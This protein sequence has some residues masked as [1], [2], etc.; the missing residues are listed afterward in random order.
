MSMY[1]IKDFDVKPD[2]EIDL[3]STDW[4]VEKVRSNPNYAQNLYAAMCNNDFMPKE[5]W[6]ILNDYVWHCSWRHAGGIVA[7]IIG[8]GDYMDFYCSGIGSFLDGL[9]SPG[10]VAEGVVT[11]EVR[12]DLS[13]LGWIVVDEPQRD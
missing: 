9:E 3:N 2:L 8:H 6:S 4:L 12:M 1:K 5:A 10:N 13:T 11:D 7:D